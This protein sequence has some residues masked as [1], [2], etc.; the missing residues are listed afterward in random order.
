MLAQH[1][2]LRGEYRYADFGSVAETFFPAGSGDQV[3]M[4]VR[5]R[6]STAL[7]GIAYKF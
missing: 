2:T 7:V 5:L 3:R 6:T 4:N 1:W